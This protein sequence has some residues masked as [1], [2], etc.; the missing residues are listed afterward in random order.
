MRHLLFIAARHVIRYPKA[1]AAAGAGWIDGLLSRR[2]RT[3]AAVALAN[4]MARIVWA[5][6][7]TGEVYRPPA[8]PAA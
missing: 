3:V 7:M 1:R 6:M 4:K 8:A 5:M 2:S